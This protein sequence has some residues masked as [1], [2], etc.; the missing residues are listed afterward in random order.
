M[1]PAGV[2]F[3]VDDLQ[4]AG[5][6]RA[7]FQQLL[8]QAVVG[9]LV[10]FADE[11]ADTLPHQRAA[12]TAQQ[13]R[14]RQIG[15]N[16]QPAFAHRAVTHRRQVVQLEV[17]GPRGFQQQLGAQQLVVLHLQFDLVHLQL[18]QGAL[19]ARHRHGFGWLVAQRQF[20]ADDGFGLQAQGLCGV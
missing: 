19:H 15:L 3:Q 17:A 13:R 8:A 11:A 1:H 4:F 2:A 7:D 10:V 5:L 18:V 6:G 9:V 14:H 16:D 12:R 20:V